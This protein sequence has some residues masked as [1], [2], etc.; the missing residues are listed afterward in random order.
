MNFILFYII[1]HNFEDFFLQKQEF[2]EEKKLLEK[3]EKNMGFLSL[4]SLYQEK[5]EFRYNS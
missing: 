5:N 1:F 2:V 3:I 4:I